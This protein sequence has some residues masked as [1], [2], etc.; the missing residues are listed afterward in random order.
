MNKHVSVLLNETIEGLNIIEDRRETSIR[1][2]KK[3]LFK[4]NSIIHD[5]FYGQFQNIM[6]CPNPS[7]QNI[8]SIFEPFFCISLPLASKEIRIDV[9]CFFI[10]YDI[11]IFMIFIFYNIIII[12][13]EVWVF[14]LIYY[15]VFDEY[16]LVL[17]FIYFYL[18]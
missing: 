9:V 1:E 6:Y 4:E 15:C 5:L 12:R 16:L 7:C 8:T 14:R 2:W 18:L 13:I 10:F 17:L 11:L 3:M